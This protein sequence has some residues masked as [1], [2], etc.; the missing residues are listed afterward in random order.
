[1]KLD[2]NSISDD[3]DFKN[4]IKRR[5]KK[6]EEFRSFVQATMLKT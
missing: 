2:A 6:D 3:R 1:M 5:L 4:E